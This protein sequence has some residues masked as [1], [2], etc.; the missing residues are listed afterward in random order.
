MHAFPRVLGGDRLDGG[1]SGVRNATDGVTPLRR[2]GH[3]DEDLRLP[4]ASPA[5]DEAYAGRCKHRLTTK[6]GP[7][8]QARARH[9]ADNAIR[10]G[11]GKMCGVSAPSSDA[12][13][14]EEKRC[15]GDS[16]FPA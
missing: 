1:E 2:H 15:E 16:R 6:V 14:F 5:P 10:R 12:P 13:S 11:R 7:R 9:S 8:S 4:R 3:K